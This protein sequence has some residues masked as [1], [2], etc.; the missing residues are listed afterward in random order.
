M[1]IVKLVCQ[2]CGANLDAIDQGRI[3]QC[4]YCGTNN[5]IQAK[6]T[7]P[8]PRHPPQVPPQNF[9]QP[10]FD[11]RAQANVGSGAT[12]LIV[13]LTIIPLVLGAAVALFLFRSGIETFQQFSQQVDGTLNT[14]RGFHWNSGHPHVVDVNGDDVDDVVG[15][16]QEIGEQKLLLT[17]ISGSNS[18]TL[19]EVELGRLTDLPDRSVFVEPTSKLVLVAMGPALHAHDLATGNQRWVAILPDKIASVAL[20]GDHLWVGT[21]DKAAS[22]VT[23]VDGKVSPTAATPSS[24]AKPLRDDEE[25]ELIP[26]L[27]ELDLDY[28]QYEGLRVNQAFCPIENL[29]LTFGYRHD[30][31][32]K[33]CSFPH[34]LAFVTRDKG[35]AVPYF[36]GYDRDTKAERWRVQLTKAGTL[37]TVDTGFS[38]PRA[39]MFGDEA[40]V[41]LVPSSDNNAR[42]RRISLIDG[43]TVWETTLVRKHTEN[44]EGIGIGKNRVF[45]N[46]GQGLRVLSLA[47]GTELASLGGF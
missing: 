21:S 8:P 46:Y 1:A 34:G 4:G 10:Q 39:E 20:D 12:K 44:V 35:T 24:A 23:L 32:Q 29:P 22:S 5:Q 45:V 33:R 26:E 42:I 3:I 40:I 13:I 30:G 6:P 27:G 36:L 15:T 37:E 28:N 14:A 18:A 17:A 16:T 31:D 25:Y 9:P 38:Q 7:V 41:S 2:G 47:D 43:S 19:W 11:K